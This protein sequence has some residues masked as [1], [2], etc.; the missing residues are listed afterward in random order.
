MRVVDDEEYAKLLASGEWF[1]TP[2]EAKNV[3]KDYEEQIRRDS[4]K[5]GR[6]VRKIEQNVSI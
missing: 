3:R 6:P 1:E 5:R 4:R 2:N